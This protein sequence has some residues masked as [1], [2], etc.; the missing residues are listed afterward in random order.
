MRYGHG[1]ATNA[2]CPLC[3]SNNGISHMLGSCTHPMM[4]AMF[5]ER[6]NAA[7]RMILKLILEGSHG[8]RYIL[9]DVGS[10]AALDSWEH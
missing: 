1:I 6:H 8:D 4:K 3:G 9:T 10:E 2:D 5:I 7:A